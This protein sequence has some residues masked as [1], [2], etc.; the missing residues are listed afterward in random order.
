MEEGVV[1]CR[2][3]MVKTSFERGEMVLLPRWRRSPARVGTVSYSL[4][5][6]LCFILL[7]AHRVVPGPARSSSSGSIKNAELEIDWEGGAAGGPAAVT[8][9]RGGRSWSYL[10]L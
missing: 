8:A 7:R 10:V 5:V 1:R 3:A 6:H 4:Y 9:V 2:R